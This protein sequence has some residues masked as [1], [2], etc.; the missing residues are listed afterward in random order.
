MINDIKAKKSLGQNFLK[1]KKA[2]FA[3][4]EAGKISA[5]DTVLEIGPGQGALTEKLLETGAKII[6]VEKDDRLI[7]FLSE[8]FAKE[9]ESSQF[10]LIH[11]DI[12]EI[13]LSLF[14]FTPNNYKLIANIPYYITGLIF[15]KFLSG[16]IQPSKL[17][18]MVQKE[19]A[20]R[21]V[22]NDGKESL[23]SL[24]VKAYGHPKKIMKVEKENFSPKPKVD[25]AIILIDNISRDYF[26]D[27]NEGVFFEVIKAGFA[28]KRKVLITNLKGLG[29]NTNLHEVFSRANIPEKARSEDLNLNDW[30]NIIKN[31][32]V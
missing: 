31:L 9:T 10:K 25:S 23:L 13:D 30:K 26:N 24:S 1:S 32:E 22:A 20:D 19:I 12:L 18:M 4:I 21:I 8:K 29:N 6:A 27:I 3:M 7:E 16:N 11:G 28:H 5:D 14:G 15:R 2:L 17:V